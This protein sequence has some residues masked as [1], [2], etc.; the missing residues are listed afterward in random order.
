LVAGS[1]ND[2]GEDGAGCV[3]TG[4]SG[5]AHAGAIVDYECSNIFVSHCFDFGSTFRLD[6]KWQKFK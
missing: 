3:V 1:A 2:G 5:L 6:N 4:E